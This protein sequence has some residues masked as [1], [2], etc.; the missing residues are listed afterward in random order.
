M[1]FADICLQEVEDDGLT[2]MSDTIRRERIR[3]EKEYEGVRVLPE[4]RGDNARI[5]LQINVAFGDAM[6]RSRRN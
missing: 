3:D 1:I 4:A 6:V 2:F 5:P